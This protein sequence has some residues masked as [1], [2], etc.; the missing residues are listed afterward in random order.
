[1]ALAIFDLDNTLLAGDSDHA[2]GAFLVA[3]GVVDRADYQRANDYFYARYQAGTLDIHEYVQ[4]VVQ[5]LQELG[6][7]KR[8]A[9]R[10]QFLQEVV[11]SM[12]APGSA[13]LL[14]RHRRQGDTLLI[15]TATIDFITRPI[16]D[17]LGVPSLLAT[18]P[19]Q[20]AEGQFTG[21]IDGVPAFRE[22]K[23]KRLG[24]WLQD[25]DDTFPRRWFYSDSHNDLPLLEQVTDPVAVDPDPTLNQIAEHRSWPVISLR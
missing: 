4:F 14:D 6:R 20:D 21:R 11:S 19:E 23:I 7:N 9:L 2:W 12:I 1:M 24:D 10:E 22:G 13:A 16:A 5:P 8:E 15:I 18:Q 25:Q 17:L 3:Q